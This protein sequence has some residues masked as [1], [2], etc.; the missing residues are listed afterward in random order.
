MFLT[1]TQAAQ[2]LGVTAHQVRVLCRAGRIKADKFG[3]IWMIAREE[4]VRFAE[5][6]RK[7][8]RQK[9]ERENV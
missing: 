7:R 2:T 8:G 3:H 4:V 5:F 1:T 6:P 9:K